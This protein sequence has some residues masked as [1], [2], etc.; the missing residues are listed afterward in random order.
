MKNS[1]L[2]LRTKMSRFGRFTDSYINFFTKNF[3]EV[4][5]ASMIIGANIGGIDA[6]RSNNASNFFKWWAL[7]CGVGITAPFI[8]LFAIGPLAYKSGEIIVTE[9]KKI[10]Q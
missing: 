9:F 4:L 1:N 7:G 10:S 8:P 5:G 2:N 3:V 6:I